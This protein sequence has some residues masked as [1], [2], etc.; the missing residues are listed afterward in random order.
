MGNVKRYGKNRGFSFVEML[1][2]SAIVAL[3]FGGLMTSVHFALKLIN[4]SRA[5]AGA[6]ALA[7]ERIEYIRSLPYASVGT[8]GGI[9]DGLIPQ[10]ATTSLNGI[11]YEERILIQYVDAP[12]DGL[13]ASDSNGILADYK[14]AKVVYSWSTQN[15]TSTLFLLTNIVP[16]GIES[17]DGGGTLTVNVFDAG[18]LPISG[19]EVHIYNDTTTTTISTSRFTNSDGVATFAGAPAAANYQIA[20]TKAG[21]SIDQTYSATTTNPSPIT[22]HIAVLESEV[23]TMNFQIDRL[24]DLLVRTVGPATGGEFLD[25]FSDSSKVYEQNNTEVVGGELVLAGGAGAYAPS[26]TAMSISAT[27]SPITAWSTATWDMVTPAGT[28]YV[29][30]VYSVSGGVATLVSDSDLPG[31]GVGFTTSPIDISGLDVGTYPTLALGATLTS[32]DVNVTPA[33]QTWGITHIISEPSIGGI[34]FTLQGDKLIGSTP[35]YKYSETHTTEGDG[36]VQIDNLEW[37]SY[38]ITL[39]T[40]A[41]DIA[42]ACPNIPYSLDPNVSDTLTLTL[43]PSEAYS[44]RVYVADTSGNPI[45]GADVTLSR[46]GFSE[47]AETSVCGQAFFSPIPAGDADYT[48]DISA[49]GFHDQTIIG[50]T[51]DGAETLSVLLNTL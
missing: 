36:E 11:T 8:V 13:G 7:N 4:N 31:N 27:P 50:V 20:V 10:S 39:N 26:G 45:S 37:D 3:V 32:G 34:G 25:D 35:T 19:A 47:E 42:S 44:I 48:V 2:T 15:G 14:Q 30:Q 24:S 16:P 12:D 43:V 46:S 6:L 21:Y 23:S 49:T 28:G 22:T 5:S 9:P 18:V 17:T 40:G 38:T 1:I 33:L 41:Y 51:V 29:V